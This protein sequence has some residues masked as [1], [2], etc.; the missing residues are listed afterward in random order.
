MLKVYSSH[1]LRPAEP[2]VVKLGI[3]VVVGVTLQRVWVAYHL[4][5]SKT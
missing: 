4:G 1:V 2:F 5:Q 3:M